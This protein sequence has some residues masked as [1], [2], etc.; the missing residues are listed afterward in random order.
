MFTLKMFWVGGKKFVKVENWNS[1]KLVAEA[2]A[3]E[4]NKEVEVS[5]SNGVST[6]Y[7]LVQPNGTWSD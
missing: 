2:K 7:G 5:F 4:L 1:G 6:G 3:K